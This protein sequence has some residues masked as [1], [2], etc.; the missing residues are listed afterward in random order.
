MSSRIHDLAALAFAASLLAACASS[1]GAPAS[2]AAGT[3]TP[4]AATAKAAPSACTQ[5]AVEV[6]NRLDYQVFVFDRRDTRNEIGTITEVGK[7]MAKSTVVVQ[8]KGRP[9]LGMA[10]LQDLGSPPTAK[11]LINCRQEAVRPGSS[12][13]FRYA[14]GN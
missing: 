3:P 1:G 8:T 7:A 5:C 2:P 11:G 4:A 14:C 13:D 9:N 10:V 6:E 12:V